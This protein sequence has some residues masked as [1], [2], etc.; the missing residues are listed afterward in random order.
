[1]YPVFGKDD[2]ERTPGVV[3][4]FMTG[5]IWSVDAFM[6]LRP[7]QNGPMGI[8]LEETLFCN[9]LETYS[10]FLSKLGVEP[11]YRWIAGV[12]KVNGAGLWVP[13]QPGFTR[14]EPGPL[15]T[16]ML[17]VVTA[18]G[19]YSP[20]DPAA[21]SLKPFFTRIYESCGLERPVWLD[22]R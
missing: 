11:P 2:E 9:A 6:V 7:V 19:A 5:E 18:E 20:G 10:A 22:G 12:Q 4:V 16:C 15:G 1:V 14:W 21:A 8:A 3:Y 17:D 13:V